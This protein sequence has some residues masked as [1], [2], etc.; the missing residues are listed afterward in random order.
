MW[1]GIHFGLFQSSFGGSP[2]SN[3]TLLN[4]AWGRW[5]SGI[6]NDGLLQYHYLVLKLL[7][8]P[9]QAYF[10]FVATVQRSQA[11]SWVSRRSDYPQS[12][13]I[14]QIEPLGR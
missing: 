7:P 1:I 9:P 14:T 5:Y 2:D 3:D 6:G 8:I 10:E 12:Q 11:L 13:Y 4:G